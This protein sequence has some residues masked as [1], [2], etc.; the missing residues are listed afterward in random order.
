[1]EGTSCISCLCLL[2]PRQYELAA[3]RD[4]LSL[5]Y[6]VFAVLSLL[7]T[8]PNASFPPW[9]RTAGCHENLFFADAPRKEQAAACTTRP[10]GL[11]RQGYEGKR[12]GIL[13]LFCGFWSAIP[14]NDNTFCLLFVLTTR[15]S[16]G[17]STLVPKAS[18]A[19]RL[20]LSALDNPSCTPLVV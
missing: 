19:T 1:M 12:H 17:F 5:T 10:P 8:F 14:P 16:F 15:V 2:F 18:N 20:F 6:P 4:M 11:V 7:H 9:V 13:P 3:E